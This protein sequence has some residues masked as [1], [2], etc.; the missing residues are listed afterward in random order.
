MKLR[1][2]IKRS[3]MLVLAFVFVTVVVPNYPVQATGGIQFAEFATHPYA[4]KTGYDANS[5]N[6]YNGE[7]LCASFWCPAGQSITTDM[8]ITRDDK[9]VAGYGDWQTN[10]DSFGVDAGGIYIAPIDV[11]TGKWDGA[12]RFV[13]VAKQ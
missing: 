13:S 2:T 8:G 1:T 5:T 6:Y 3:A 11:T 12:S 7:K 4:G 9:I 10:V